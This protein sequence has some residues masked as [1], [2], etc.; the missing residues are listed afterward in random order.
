MR[1]NRP[2]IALVWFFAMFGATA[3]FSEPL[4]TEFTYQGYLQDGGGPA[5]GVYDFKF[6]LIN[7]ATGGLVIG[8]P[9][10]VGDVAVSKGLFNAELDFGDDAFNGGQRWLVIRVRPG[11]ST[12]VYTKLEPRQK[13]TATPYALHSLSADSADTATVA[14]KL[15]GN[16][17]VEII[18]DRLV[19]RVNGATYSLGPALHMEMVQVPAGTFKMG[20][21]SDGD[22]AS[23]GADELP[24]H[25]VTLSAYWIGKYEV[26]NDQ[27]CEV[28]NWALGQGLLK[29][30]DGSTAYSSGS[31]VYVNAGDNQLLLDVD[32]AE[33]QISY[34]G[35][36]FSSETRDS[37]PMA[38]HPVVEVSWYGA[39]GF[40]NWLSEMEGLTPCYDL[41][42]WALTVPYPNG[43]RLSTEAEWERAA[44]WDDSKHW[45]YGMASDTLTGKDR[46]NYNDSS[47]NWV[48]PLG[49]SAFPYTSPVG[50]FDGVNVSPNGSVST[51]DSPSPMG[52]D[53]MSGNVWQWCQDWYDVSYY[54]SGGPPWI[55]PTG[56]SSSPSSSRVGRGGSWN[57]SSSACRSANRTAFTPE[58]TSHA[59]GFRVSRTPD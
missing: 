20:R 6:T 9:V 8:A 34:S 32:D 38:A 35:G 25:D 7:A 29:E 17:E 46:C 12:G 40:C 55:D 21:R 3:L 39:V 42:T 49:L 22:D 43:Y 15:A 26:T 16:I 47:P 5:D 18:S 41:S 53:D 48:N 57:S 14:D 4:G 30:S 31:D 50:W 58:D 37:F 1:R 28:L 2:G 44:A 23:G 19:L 51:L 10:E 33:C 24:R 54:T 45:I 52:C 11:D 36:A 27:Y 59:I 13:L 56:P